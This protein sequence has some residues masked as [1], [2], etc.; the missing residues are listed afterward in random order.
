MPSRMIADKRRYVMSVFMGDSKGILRDIKSKF[1]E[2]KVSHM[3][4]GEILDL[5]YE[6]TEKKEAGEIE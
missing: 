5:Y 6:M 4:D 1:Y 3:T 2:W